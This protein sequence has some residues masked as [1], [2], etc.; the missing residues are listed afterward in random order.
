[1][2]QVMAPVATRD[3]QDSWLLKALLR[4]VMP[5][6][7]V[8]TG[9]IWFVATVVG[10]A[11]SV[12]LLPVFLL[13]LAVFDGLGWVTYGLA[14]ME[15]ARMRLFLGFEIAAAPNLPKGFRKR[16]TYGP[17]WR[18]IG[19]G[20]LHFPLAIATYVAAVAGW[21]TSLSLL[22]MPWWLHRVPSRRADLWLI[23]VDDQATAWWLAGAGVLIAAL[24]SLLVYVL[25]TL[26]GELAKALL[27][28]TQGD[29]SRRVGELEVSR[30][31][32]VDSV[33]AERRRIERDLHDGAQQR[34]VSVA[35][36]LGRARASF[37]KDPTVSRQLLDEAHQDAK[38]AL[39]ELRD[40]ARGIHPAVLTDRGL[41]AAL[42]GLA[43]SSPV[44]VT[45]HVSVEP[46]CTPTIEAIA[47][48]VVSEALANV[49][50]HAQARQIHI[51]VERIHDRLHVKVRDDGVGGADP[52]R[53]SGLS[54]LRDRVAGVDGTLA[55]SSPPGGPTELW[56]ELPCA[57]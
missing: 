25:T 24:A 50:K 27:G 44:P 15:R 41:D 31:R 21:G 3:K 48:F 14:I 9:T 43:G 22:S 11:L 55:I 17:T 8:V 51:S 2:T 7:D 13:G 19:Y 6:A 57:S 23:H 30:S 37:D 5:L 52:I 42:S 18:S 33:D 49:A 32:V 1:M 4:A 12:G 34:L 10:L 36:N 54:G 28:P 38:R 45:V 56:A 46:R 47:Y 29:L 26:E 39:T 16:L 35:M 40:L 20:L 53:G